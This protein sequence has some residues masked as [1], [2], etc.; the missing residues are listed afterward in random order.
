MVLD[1]VACAFEPEVRQ[2][3]EHAALVGDLVGEHDIEH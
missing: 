1:D 3:G 2:A